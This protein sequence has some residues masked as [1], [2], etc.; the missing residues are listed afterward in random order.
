M[1]PRRRRSGVRSR[2]A[3]HG[4][5][6]S[7]QERTGTGGESSSRAAVVG[8]ALPAL[9]ASHR[10]AFASA[11]VMEPHLV[12]PS[13]SSGIIVRNTACGA[14]NA[15]T[16]WD[17]AKISTKSLQESR[18]AEQSGTGWGQVRET[19]DFH[20]SD[21]LDQNK[22]LPSIGRLARSFLTLPPGGGQDHLGRQRAASQPGNPPGSQPSQ[23]AAAMRSWRQRRRQRAAAN[24]LASFKLPI[25]RHRLLAADLPN[26]SLQ[27]TAGQLDQQSNISGSSRHCLGQRNNAG[28]RFLLAGPSSICRVGGRAT[29]R[30]LPGLSRFDG[31]ALAST[32]LLL[33][34][35]SGCG[36]TRKIL[37]NQ[38]PLGLGVEWKL[39]I[40]EL[41][42][43]FL[44]NSVRYHGDETSCARPIHSN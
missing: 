5:H 10:Q 21:P 39:D 35:R 1:G 23:P 26:K 22:A 4:D 9:G 24:R 33:T 25:I 3:S 17:S 36:P 16:E 8:A 44:G 7:P 37:G 20:C 15:S 32:L 34:R 43:P 30:R 12:A 28:H 40:D 38:R 13:V 11:L 29:A 31:A 27:S 19:L 42:F 41:P 6:Q 14:W 18:S 2:R